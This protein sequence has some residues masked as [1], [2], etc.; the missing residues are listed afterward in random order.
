MS[1][2]SAMSPTVNQGHLQGQESHLPVL[3]GP[4]E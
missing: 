4:N 3:K 1:L 2:W